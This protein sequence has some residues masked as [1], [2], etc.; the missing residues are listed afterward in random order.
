MQSSKSAARQRIGIVLIFTTIFVVVVNLA[1]WGMYRQ[2]EAMLESELTR[3]LSTVAVLVSQKIVIADADLITLADREWHRERLLEITEIDST[4]DLY[5]IDEKHQTLAATTNESDSLSAI[6]L[7]YRTTID[8]LFFD[9]IQTVT[10]TPLRKV[11]NIWLRSAFAPVFDVVGVPAAVI[12]VD[13]SIDYFDDLD[14]LRQR[15]SLASVISVV[16]GFALGL[17][18]SLLQRRFSKTEEELGRARTHAQLGQMVAVV[19]HEI[20]NPLMIMR[21]AAERLRRKTELPEAGYLIEEVDRLD[22]ILSGY[23]SYA[24]SGGSLLG[25]QPPVSFDLI[26]LLAEIRQLARERFPES[27]IEWSH[28]PTEQSMPMTGYPVALRQIL[29]NLITN[30][31]EASLIAKRSILLSL[32][33]QSQGSDMTL[34]LS[35]Q[36]PGIPASQIKQLFEPFATTKQNGSGLGLYLSRKIAQEMGGS[37]EIESIFDQGTTVRLTLPFKS[38]SPGVSS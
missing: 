22:G 24:K 15:L 35:D 25:T 20:K 23:L 9:T 26:S 37:I 13:A 8:S 16:A 5:L 4:I 7:L 32:T 31:V 1:F 21:G 14:R 3:R 30:A 28:W 6:A 36:G 38:V 17:I 18:F 19:S 29:L 33:L 34:V 2:T 10:L 12:A 27:T 11:G